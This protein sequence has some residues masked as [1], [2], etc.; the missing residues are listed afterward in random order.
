M[1][2]LNIIGLLI[3]VLSYSR[4]CI[5][6]NFQGCWGMQTLFFRLLWHCTENWVAI[7]FVPQNGQY[8]IIGI[9]YFN[10]QITACENSWLSLN[11]HLCKLD[12]Y[13]R[14]N[15]CLFV[16]SIYLTLYKTDTSLRRTLSAHPSDNDNSKSG[17]L[18]SLH[19]A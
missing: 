5:R 9:F 11:W 12:T 19:S 16:N 7:D 13:T 15:P 18:L 8:A 10:A 1:I 2:L 3:Q 14:V 17:S 4:Y 6:L